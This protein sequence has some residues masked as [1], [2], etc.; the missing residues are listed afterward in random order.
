MNRLC[1]SLLLFFL[2][3]GF[4]CADNIRIP[5][6]GG[7]LYQ[8]VIV[9]K[10][11]N[12]A[13][14]DGTTGSIINTSPGTKI[15]VR[16]IDFGSGRHGL[17]NQVMVEYTHPELTDN[18]FFD[19]Y[20]EDTTVPV[21][22][23]PV[24]QT[25]QGEY[26]EVTVLLNVN[27]IGSHAIY[28]RWRNHSAGLKTFGANELVPFAKVELVRTSSMNMYKFSKGEWGTLSGKH[29]VKMVWKGHN[30]AV[31]NVYL[32]S[33]D[34]S[35]IGRT[36]TSELTITSCKGGFGIVSPA[37]VG[38]VEVFTPAGLKVKELFATGCSGTIPITSGLYII[39]VTGE[40][41]GVTVKKLFVTKE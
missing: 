15:A 35:S 23:I 36:V 5:A 40:N 39:K 18:S 29:R 30:A 28:I 7:G 32:D 16:D 11:T 24:V 14:Y 37:P 22:S 8:V 17:Y 3:V 31:A 41:D 9:D 34:P 19:I 25:R 20:L 6:K 10:G 27:V 26:R 21:A 33:A 2:S 13:K 1:C 12:G 38:R 4:V